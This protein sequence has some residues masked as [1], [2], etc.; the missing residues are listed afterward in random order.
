MPDKIQAVKC[1]L[2]D[3]LHPEGSDEYL[4]LQADVKNGE[5]IEGIVICKDQKCVKK[6]SNKFFGVKIKTKKVDIDFPQDKEPY[7]YPYK[8]PTKH[9]IWLQGGRMN[10]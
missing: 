10:T 7:K 5:D 6:F 2:C 9:K 4:V 8:P 3:K 1:D